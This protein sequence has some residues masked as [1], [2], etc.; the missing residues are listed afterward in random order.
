MPVDYKIVEF[1]LHELLVKLEKAYRLLD[2]DIKL[3]QRIREC[4][5]LI[6]TKRYTVAVVGEF[7]RGKSSL[8]NAL[9]GAKILPADVTPTTATINR[10]TFSPTPKTII[11]YKDGSSEEIG[12]DDL[13]D[14]VTKLS[15]DGEN[16]AVKVKEATI[17]YPTRI[18]QNHVD[19]IDTPGLNDE[20]RMTKITIDMLENIDAAIVPIHARVPFS[21]TE[22][23]FVC[24]LLESDNINTI[25]FVM[26]FMDQLDEDDYEYDSYVNSIVTRIKSEIFT[27]LKE[28]SSNEQVIKKA[29]LIL[30]DMKLYTVSS[31]LAL[32]SFITN[33]RKDLKKSGF[34]EF[35]TNLLHIVTAKQT[36][37]AVLKCVEEIHILIEEAE[38]Q[39]TLKTE[40]IKS[41]INQ[42][43]GLPKIVSGYR[44]N[45]KKKL[46]A[47]FS[48]GYMN[49]EEAINSLHS[50]KNK[51]ITIF[52]KKLSEK[53]TKD[54]NSI[55]DA[56]SEANM[57]CFELINN[58]GVTH[59]KKNI[60]QLLNEDAALFS[61]YRQNI[62]DSIYLTFNIPRQNNF[63]TL[64]YEAAD[65]VLRK[66]SFKWTCSSIPDIN[67]LKNINVI[68]NAIPAVDR[69]INDCIERL[70][71]AIVDIR[72]KWFLLVEE[73]IKQVAD[74]VRI[75]S[76]A[77]RDTV[78]TK[79]KVKDHNYY[80]LQD[81]FKEILERC[82]KLKNEV[83]VRI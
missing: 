63:E 60:L 7:K 52:I 15:V 45:A 38:T 54:S 80:T 79:S 82:D 78:D 42:L 21:A 26:T 40:E 48:A 44:T 28:R 3:L 10:I 18:C 23:N 51:A 50:Y 83:L 5:D 32:R 75:E 65:N 39:N 27:E 37:N 46:D 11:N 47:I 58:D 74:F 36:E 30:D 70:N 33:N 20:D 41:N 67:D 71:N 57:E 69:S 14:Y 6:K 4:M 68:E 66:E 77:L 12:I 72:K 2:F 17:Y 53:A 9:L 59:V 29:H 31:T 19:I 76:S 61:F 49:L 22:K 55:R 64:L 25:V 8:I 34:E 62:M 56:L 13:C 24:R 43:E 1:E 16:R 35:S 73:D 81:D